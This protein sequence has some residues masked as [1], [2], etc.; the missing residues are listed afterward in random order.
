M[1]GEVCPACGRAAL[2]WG[3][4]RFGHPRPG[5]PAGRRTC[6]VSTPTVSTKSYDARSG[7]QPT[8]ARF[9]GDPTAYVD[10]PIGRRKLEDQRLREGWRDSRDLPPDIRESK[11]RHADVKKWAPAMLEALRTNSTAPIDKLTRDEP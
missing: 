3:D 1:D 2:T 10:G 11:D 4:V 5:E 7:Y 8:L 6:M 9:Q